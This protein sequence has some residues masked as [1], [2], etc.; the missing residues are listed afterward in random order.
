MKIMNRHLLL[1]AGALLAGVVVAACG[2]ARIQGG[3][4]GASPLSDGVYEGASQNGPNA[5][6]VRVRI[7]DGEL[8]AIEVLRNGGSWLGRRAVPTVPYRILEA[9]STKVD[10]VTGATNSS[11]VVMNAVEQAVA[12]ARAAA[13]PDRPREE[14]EP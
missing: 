3:P 1:A 8:D 9:Q 4:L 5:A 13:A 2:V 7:R 6:R 14:P 12:K 10:A 11:R